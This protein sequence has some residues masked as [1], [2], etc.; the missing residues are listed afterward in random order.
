MVF[1]SS[2]PLGPTICKGGKGLFFPLSDD[3][4]Y[5]APWLR[6]VIY[7]GAMAYIFLA[8]NVVSDRFTGGIMRITCK[9]IR[10]W[11]RRHFRF[12]TKKRW[13]QTLA[14]I[15]LLGL[16]S[17]TP[18]I[19]LSIGEILAND[20]HSGRLGPSVI[21]GSAAFNLFVI[22]AVCIFVVPS[23]SVRLIKKTGVFAV[24]AVFSIFCYS[25]ML[26]IIKYSSPDVIDIWEGVLTLVFF[27][28]FLIVSWLVDIGWSPMQYIGEK[29]VEVE[30]TS[31]GKMTT[32]AD[33]VPG[34]EGGDM[35]GKADDADE[36]AIYDS[37]EATAALALTSTCVVMFPSDTLDINTKEEEQT[38]PVIVGLRTLPGII[39]GAIT[40]KYR[41][42]RLTAVPGY[43][44]KEDSGELHF[45]HD[46]LKQQIMLTIM[47]GRIYKAQSQFQ[48][49]LDFLEGSCAFSETDD[50][51]KESALLTVTIGVLR[52]DDEVGEEVDKP[53]VA[54]RLV[55]FMDKT[56]GIDS[57][58]LGLKI[59]GSTI[60]ESF[61]S[62]FA[63]ET[64]KGE[65]R[66]VVDYVSTFIALPWK[67]LFAFTVPPAE[68]GGGWPCFVACIAMFVFLVASLLD[69]TELFSCVAG[70]Q[71]SVTGLT[72]VSIGTSL[73]DLFVS[74]TA[75]K[76]NEWA[77]ASIV[78]VT[79]SNSVNVLLGIGFPWTLAAIY[80]N[81]V[82]GQ[83]LADWRSLYPSLVADY[84]SG[85]FV[86]EG[87]DLGFNVGVFTVG[88]L[89]AFMVLRLR[90]FK[91]GG[92][93][94]GPAWS[95][96]ISAGFLVCCWIIY[97]LLCVWKAVFD[98]SNFGDQAS[99][100]LTPENIITAFTIT[101]MMAFIITAGFDIWS[102]DWWRYTM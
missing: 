71:D 55:R 35:V 87:G 26:F 24:T 61:V 82:T 62:A 28:L 12:A 94:G 23:P 42:D 34:G 92:E 98:F 36:E 66:N 20:F 96:A 18:E 56:I 48:V 19:L 30:N 4:Q 58:R 53:P 75:A 81:G 63:T 60:R 89:V 77:D 22:V 33:P 43:D 21:V 99:T 29:E 86:V 80:W 17:S 90:R 101:V 37:E 84:P 11:D 64:E 10:Y 8:V 46:N 5:W 40:C 65:P 88:A 14:N 7:L 39:P 83:K 57:V 25:W 27:P 68:F 67:A 38:I 102:G 76:T 13:N 52:E 59:W 69:M 49:I 78:N 44:F 79:G 70:I 51:G 50:G 95:K 31:F 97:V 16:A 32:P 45:S 85:A 93:L 2:D 15:T 54:L 72:L 100:A 47:P 41:T 9:R 6:T 1:S 73:P 3:E 74:I 91:F